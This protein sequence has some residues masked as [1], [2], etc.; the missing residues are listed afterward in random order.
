MFSFIFSAFS[1]DYHFIYIRLDASMKY[2]TVTNEL[3]AITSDIVKNNGKFVTLFSNSNPKMTATTIDEMQEIIN[4]FSITSSFMAIL[5]VD[6][7][8]AWLNAF[9]INEICSIIN[10]NIAINSDV[11][12]VV[13]DMFVGD[14]FI[15]RGMHNHLV[16]KLLYASGLQN[17]N[18]AINYY[19]SSQL[20][21]DKI[22]FSEIYQKNNLLIQLK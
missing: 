17:T 6:E 1:Q 18:M 7:I 21:E 4:L 11:S 3:N 8:D 16:A 20:T 13:F 15:E 9:E 14:D 12:S 2:S 19:N 22:F 10:T 5:L